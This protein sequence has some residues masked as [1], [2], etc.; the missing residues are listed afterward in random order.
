MEAM[1]TTFLPVLAFALV[2]KHLGTSAILAFLLYPSMFV[3]LALVLIYTGKW[4]T[5]PADRKRSELVIVAALFAPVVSATAQGIADSLSRL[6]RLKY[7]LYVH[8]VD[9]IF[10]LW[11]FR[12]TCFAHRCL[13][14]HSRL[15]TCIHLSWISEYAGSCCAA[16]DQH[17]RSPKWHSFRSPVDRDTGFPV[18]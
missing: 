7:D 9:A 16:A 13:L 1:S 6:R 18:Q 14:P 8:R 10:L 2:G 11:L 17:L 3:A 15:R 5:D 4:F 12:S